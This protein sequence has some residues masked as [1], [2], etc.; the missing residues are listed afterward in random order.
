VIDTH[1]HLS[2][3]R[4]KKDRALALARARRSGVTAVI[5]VGY[6]LASSERAVRLAAQEPDVWASVGVHPHEVEKTPESTVAELRRLALEPRVV[7]IGEIGLDFFRNL[8]PP[9]MQREWFARQLSLATEVGLP[10]IVHTR[11]AMKEMLETLKLQAPPRRGVLHC[12]S[13][14]PEQASRAAELGFSLGFGGTLTYGVPALEESAR[15]AARETLLLETDAPY[16]V[17]EPKDTKRNEP[18]LLPRVRERLADLR[19]ESEEEVDAFTT[20]NA[21]RLFALTA[22]R[23]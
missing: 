19:G 1:C 5:E 7:A 11:D 15:N 6:D 12:Y 4:F 21:V 18:S 3:S 13:G 17:P 23:R 20:E 14:D 16:L 8:S 10:V 2:S 9:D 22:H